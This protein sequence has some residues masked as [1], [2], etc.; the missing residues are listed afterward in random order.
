M[1]ST[2]PNSTTIL[3]FVGLATLKDYPFC[4]PWEHLKKKNYTTLF[5]IT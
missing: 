1:I 5:I 2:Y 4:I 3:V